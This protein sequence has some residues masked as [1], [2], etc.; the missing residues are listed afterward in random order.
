MITRLADYFTA[1]NRNTDHLL[2]PVTAQ[3]HFG[4][5]TQPAERS[6]IARSASEIPPSDLRFHRVSEIPLSELDDGACSWIYVT[7]FDS[8]HV[9]LL[10]LVNFFRYEEGRISTNLRHFLHVRGARVPPYCC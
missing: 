8:F 7:Y 3:H 6:P 9:A 4:H 10:R 2:M 1:W 5:S